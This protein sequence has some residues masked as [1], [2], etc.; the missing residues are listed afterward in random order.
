MANKEIDIADFFTTDNEVNG[1]W[2]EP[3]PYGK[4]TG[5]EFKLLGIS[6]DVTVTASEQYDKEMDLAKKETDVVKR[7]KLETEALVRRVGAMVVD[8]RGKDGVVP[9]INGK[10]LTYT[11]EN[12]EVILRGS[13]AIRNEFLKVIGSGEDFMTKKH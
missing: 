6:S 13:R 9:M 5:I 4:P 11:R 2:Y 10:P 8:I 7:D 3:K 12:V 1:V